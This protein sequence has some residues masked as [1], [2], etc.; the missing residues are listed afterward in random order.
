MNRLSIPIE[1]ETL[2]GETHTHPLYTLQGM[3]KKYHRKTNKINR[4]ETFTFNIISIFNYD[5]ACPVH[6]SILVPFFLP[7]V[8]QRQYFKAALC[9]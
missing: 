6:M 5:I 9:G 3:K 2:K 7:F 1:M 4:E 8:R